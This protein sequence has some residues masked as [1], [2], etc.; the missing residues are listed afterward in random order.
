MQT[1]DTKAPLDVTRQEN[2]EMIIFALAK[3]CS[4]EILFSL[5][6]YVSLRHV[7]MA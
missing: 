1:P 5:K 6:L 7:F 3:K 2:V 4:I